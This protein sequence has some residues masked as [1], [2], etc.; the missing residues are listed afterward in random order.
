M[1]KTL[2]WFVISAAFIGPGTVTTATSAGANFGSQLLWTIIFAV[3]ACIVLQE[4]A[5]RINIAS[6]QSLGL[7]IARMYK[8]SGK[9]SFIALATVFTI[10][11]G[12]AAYEAGNILGAVSGITLTLGINRAWL[13]FGIILI[14]AILLYTNKFKVL[15]NFLAIIIGLMGLGLLALVFMIDLN[16]TEVIKGLTL[17][18][19]PAGAELLTIGL[20][21]TTVVPYNLFLGSKVGEAQDIRTMRRGLAISVV[22]GG[23]ISLALILIGSQVEGEFSFA[24]VASALVRISGKWAHYVFAFGLFAAGLT[25]AITAPWAASI[26]VV[27]TLKTKNKEKAFRLTWIIVLSMGLVFGVSDVKPIPVII[28]AQALNGIILPFLSITIFFI[29]N[30]KGLM[31]E[32]TNGFVGNMALLFVVWITLILGLLNVLKAFFAGFGINQ[33]IDKPILVA[34]GLSSMLFVFGLGYRVLRN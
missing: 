23:L 30:N 34:I 4:G 19:I 13:T 12:C 32:F 26:S 11:L 7:A 16:F 20:I 8:T 15:T 2:V 1:R 5:A 28:L 27:T 22:V 10:V 14:A 24:S 33:V 21:G 17:P 31:K 6:G 3:F 25:S 18:S 29:V 9:N